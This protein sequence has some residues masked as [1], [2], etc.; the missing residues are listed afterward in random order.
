M[1]MLEIKIPFAGFYETYLAAMVDDEI[2]SAFDYEGTGAG[3]ENMPDDFYMKAD[4]SYVYHALAE[5]YVEYA[6]DKANEFL[7]LEEPIKLTFKDMTS[8]REYNFSTYRLFAEISEKDVLKLY[9]FTDK[10]VLERV[11]SDRF[12]SRSGFASFY[13]NSLK[14]TG[15]DYKT[16]W[17]KDVL[18]WD[19][20]QLET[21]LIAA[22]LTALDKA[23]GWDSESKH[24]EEYHSF[25]DM[26]FI[27]DMSSSGELGNLIYEH[28]PKE[29]VDMMNEY[30]EKAS[31][32]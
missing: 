31:A 4:Y 1:T 25:D 5:Q 24:F 14:E 3:Y 22:I 15:Q 2:E 20:N 16:S 10:E 11:V 19:H 12:T 13:Q 6:Q 27:E 9:A 8:P 18:R 32:A 23:Q 7:E 21:L 17:A 28:L 29:C 30:Y 26:P